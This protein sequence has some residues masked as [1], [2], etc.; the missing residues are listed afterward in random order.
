[1]NGDR[2]NWRT[3]TAV[4]RRIALAAV[5]VNNKSAAN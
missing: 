5:R 4:V 2:E 3:G 1:M